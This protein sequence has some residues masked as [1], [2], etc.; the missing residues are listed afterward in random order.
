MGADGRLSEVRSEPIAADA[1]PGKDGRNDAKLKLIAGLVGVSLDELKQREAQR[2]TGAWCCWCR[3][4]SRAWRSPRRSP[5][6]RGWRAT[7]R[8]G[9]VR[10]P[11]R[12]RRPPGRPP[13][14]W[15]TCSS[16]GPVRGAR[17]LDHR[18]RDLD[19]G[20][21]R[22][23]SDL[24][25][26]PVI[27]AT[28]MD[29]MGTVYTGLGLYE[30]AARLL[31]QAHAKRQRALGEDHPDV[32]RS[33]NH[34]GEVLRLNA[35]YAEAEQSL[36]AALDT[37]RRVHGPESAE[38]SETLMALAELLSEMGRYEESEPLIG[39]ALRIRRALYGPKHPDVAACIEALG[40]NY[41][42]RGEYAKAE[43]NLRLALAMRRELHP[44]GHPLLAQAMGQPRLGAA[45]PGEIRRGRAAAAGVPGA[46]AAPVRHR[47][48]GNRRRH[49]QPRLHCLTP[50]T[51]RIIPPP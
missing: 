1:R 12:R 49:E 51:K 30:P 43:P 39:E 41:Q 13:V 2:A 22:I 42:D 4:R 25:D 47:A 3:P 45:E 18:A 5:V 10:E 38:V 6:R 40:L 8:S 26:Q 14:S 29:T 44:K 50:P 48:P 28:L 19:K 23:E 17:Q 46:E 34:L 16:V 9:S 15:S 36:R 11:R 31:R 24:V 33:L 20:A 21:A 35:D 27:Q 7:R 37:R 32:A